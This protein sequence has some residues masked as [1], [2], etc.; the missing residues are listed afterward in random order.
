M[1]QASQNVPA[2]ALIAHCRIHLNRSSCHGAA[3]GTFI[4]RLSIPSDRDLT[5]SGV[6]IAQ[7]RARRTSV[8]TSTSLRHTAIA[9][10][11]A[12]AGLV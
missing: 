5:V 2:E 12:G 1:E 3:T 7:D 11:R 4:S 6:G 10:V 9:R 8:V